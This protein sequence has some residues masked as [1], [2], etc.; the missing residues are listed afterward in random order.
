VPLAD[1]SIPDCQASG[2]GARPA[3]VL[4]DERMARSMLLD[5]AAISALSDPL[6]AASSE[7]N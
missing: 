2:V 1:S 4:G 6:T 5:S 7:P 3:K